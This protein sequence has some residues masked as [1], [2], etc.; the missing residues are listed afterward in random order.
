MDI[1]D[2]TI[3]PFILNIDKNNDLK[4]YEKIKQMLI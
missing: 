3:I 2:K 1:I 4:E